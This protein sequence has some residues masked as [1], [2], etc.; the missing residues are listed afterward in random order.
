MEFVSLKLKKLNPYDT[1]NIIKIN[2]PKIYHLV[3]IKQQ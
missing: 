1:F 2:F 3:F